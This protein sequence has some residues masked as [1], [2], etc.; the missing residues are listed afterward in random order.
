MAVVRLASAVVLIRFRC[1]GRRMACLAVPKTADDFLAGLPRSEWK[2]LYS[3]EILEYDTS[4]YDFVSALAAVMEV[5]SSEEMSQLHQVGGE[6]SVMPLC[7]S[8]WRAKLLAGQKLR[9]D[10]PAEADEASATPIVEAVSVA[11]NSERSES[12]EEGPPRKKTK[13]R[14]LEKAMGK[15]WAQSREYNH[16]KKLYRQFVEEWV[17]PS[18]GLGEDEPT[19]RGPSG[20]IRAVYQHE[21][22]IRV[23]MPGKYP[24][25]K[26]H[27]DAD[28]LNKEGELNFWLP[29]T[30]V[31]GSNSLQ[32]ESYPN[33]GDFTPF[34]M[35]PGQLVR[36]WG[37]R[38][39]HYT[40]ANETDSTRVSFDFRVIPGE[41]LQGEDSKTVLKG[42]KSN[43][44]YK[45][46]YWP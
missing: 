30:K 10:K 46:L 42:T 34:E 21:P 14:D 33:A 7:P 24:S 45:T 22:S 9:I 29:V 31:W 38:C 6:A 11:S 43:Y 28:Y 17:L 35:E 15:R 25:I 27:C 8:L 40:L 39:R 19:K 20:S 2:P 12:L 44:S 41:L 16:L 32:V 37:N 1:H 36:F 5:G 18:L 23:Q 13:K 26:L 4:K 3:Q